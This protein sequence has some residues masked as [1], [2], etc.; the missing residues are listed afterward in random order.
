MTRYRHYKGGIYE[1]DHIKTVFV[2]VNV[3]T[4]EPFEYSEDHLLSG[5]TLLDGS[6][7]KRFEEIK[8]ESNS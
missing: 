1:L 2:C 3:A 4:G 8:D 7:V 5:V 6:V